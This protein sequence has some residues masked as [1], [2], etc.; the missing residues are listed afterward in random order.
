MPI[1]AI[2]I[3]FVHGLESPFTTGEPLWVDLLP[4]AELECGAILS[5]L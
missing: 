5:I 3:G 2:G 4:S 1:I